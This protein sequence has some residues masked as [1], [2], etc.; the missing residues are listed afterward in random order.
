M[1]QTASFLREDFS[2][3]QGGP[4]FK[5][6]VRSG[7]IKPDFARPARRATFLALFIWLP[8]FVLS[9]VHSV[10]IGPGSGLSF[11]SDFA[12]SIRFLICVP[13]LIIAEV[14]LEARTS[15]VV[16]HFINSGLV[17]RNDYTTFDS[18]V[19]NSAKLRDSLLAEI[20]IVAVVVVSVAFLR[21]EYSG[22]T[23]TWQELVTEAGPERTLAGWWYLVVGL[24]FFQFLLWRW[25]W[26]FFIWSEFLRA[27]SRLD[28]RLIPS[29]PDLAAGLG[30]LGAAQA[31]YGIV[32]FA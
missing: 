11:L 16:K 31:R 12:V 1:E 21:L 10:A 14:V 2:L 26:R 8:M 28:L 19:R 3:T 15:T 4:F 30:F 9:L 7:L 20:V 6:L 24:P 27:V 5:L 25:L 22:S 32:V 17:Q 29:H 13:L 18:A 23:S